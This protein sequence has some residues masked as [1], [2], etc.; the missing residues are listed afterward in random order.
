VAARHG[1]M[2]EAVS[3]D[4]L[5]VEGG[6]GGVAEGYHVF[7]QLMELITNKVPC[8]TSLYAL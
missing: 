8:K 2:E 7:V 6:G 4:V 5:K 3:D 1:R